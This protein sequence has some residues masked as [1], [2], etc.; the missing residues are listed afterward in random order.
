MVTVRWEDLYPGEPN[1]VIEGSNA[2]SRPM[3]V[4]TL[5]YVVNKKNNGGF[6]IVS[7]DDRTEPIYAIIDRGNYD[8]LASKWSG[9]QVQLVNLTVDA[10][11]QDMGMEVTIVDYQNGVADDWNLLVVPPMLKTQWQVEPMSGYCNPFYKGKRHSLLSVAVGQL[12]S[13][14]SAVPNNYDGILDWKSILAECEHESNLFPGLP[15]SDV[16]MHQMEHLLD[17]LDER[18]DGKTW[19]TDTIRNEDDSEI[20]ALFNS[21]GLSMTR[22]GR[23]SLKEVEKALNPYTPLCVSFQSEINLI[24]DKCKLKYFVMD[25]YHRVRYYSVTGWRESILPHCNWGIHSE[26]NGHFLAR[27]FDRTDSYYSE[28]YKSTTLYGDLLDD[29]KFSIITKL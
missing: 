4:D 28:S 11:I 19:C 5:F 23:F 13:Y 1:P 14:Y 21:L 26:W 15:Y 17:Y 29:C 24:K 18:V 3:A 9:D 25:G 16:S 8:P 2:I 10:I 27:I 6:T 12:M 7:A 22:F 20:S